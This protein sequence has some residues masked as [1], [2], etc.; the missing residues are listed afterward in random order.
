MAQSHL[1]IGELARRTGVRVSTIRYYGDVGLLPEAGRGFGGQRHY[2][3]SHVERLTFIRRCRELGFSQDDVRTLL[4]H[5]DQS[6]ASCED[7]ARLAKKHLETVRDKLA[8]LQA[9]ENSL[10]GMICAC[11]GGRI[12]DCRIVEVLAKDN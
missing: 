3:A 8:A 10:E 5:A 9:L 1:R 11:Q 6:D 2:G 7:V 12:E 4:I